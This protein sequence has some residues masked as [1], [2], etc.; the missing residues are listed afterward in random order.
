MGKAVAFRLHPEPSCNARA[1]CE[2]KELP[3]VS[4]VYAELVVLGMDTNIRD[5]GKLPE[6][7]EGRNTVV[8][9]YALAASARAWS[10]SILSL[11]LPRVIVVRVGTIET[12]SREEV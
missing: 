8:S 9:G 11:S 4:R 1:A 6:P 10:A 2:P 3:L 7:R 5:K 12:R